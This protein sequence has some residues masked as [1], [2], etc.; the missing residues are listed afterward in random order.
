MLLG[1]RPVDI[2]IPLENACTSQSYHLI[3][4]GQEG[5][6]VGHQSSKGLVE[7][8]DAHAKRNRKLWRDGK[9][10][11]PIPPPYFRFRRRAGQRYS[12]FYTRFFPEPDV[13]VEGGGKLPSVRF[14]FFEVPPGSVFRATIA[15]VAATVLIWLI[16][17]VSSRTRTQDPG[18]DVPAFLL[19]VPAIAAAWLGFDT[20][21]KRL[22]EGTLAARLSLAL[23]ALC[24]IAASGLFMIF[25]AKLHYF[26]WPNP[27]HMEIL[28][29]TSR[30]WTVLTLIS[31]LNTLVTGYLY[32]MR[33]WE[34]AHL[35]SREDHLSA[36]LEHG[37]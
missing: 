29:N 7:Y 37:G 23:T 18:T 1:A 25:K 6:F 20:D 35:S 2:S 4:D 30:S 33:A 34:F 22:L 3:V 11:E 27:F 28:G 31:A 19:V 8:C 12:H 21:H 36:H 24:S 32:C 5:V 13:D 10:A 16:A 15:S 9:S 17:F 26:E 14:R